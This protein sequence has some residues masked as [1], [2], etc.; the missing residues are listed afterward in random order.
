MTAST[1]WCLSSQARALCTPSFLIPF[2]ITVCLL[3]GREVIQGANMLSCWENGERLDEGIVMLEG[4]NWCYQPLV[5]FLDSYSGAWSCVWAKQMAW[6]LQVPRLLFG[7]L[8][9]PLPPQKVSRAI[10]T[11]AMGMCQAVEELAGCGA[12][13]LPR[14]VSTLA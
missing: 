5:W 1:L 7:M 13:N 8:L 11:W 6:T 3:S 4:V 12:Q 2:H 14:C 9:L 10:H